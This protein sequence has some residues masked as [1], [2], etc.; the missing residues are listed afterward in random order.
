VIRARPGPPRRRIAT[1]VV[2]WFDG[3][4]G[5]TRIVLF[6]ALLAAAAALLAIVLVPAE[7]PAKAPFT[8]PW[9]F[10]AGLFVV[11]EAKVI[12]VHLGRSAHSLS[13]SEIPIVIGLFLVA[14]P[15]FIVSRLVG[16]GLGL[17]F[18][19]RQS[20]VKILFNLA[21]FALCSVI[22]VGVVHLGSTAG[23]DLGP[24][25]W[26]AV[27]TA[28]LLENV[29]GIL[30][31]STAISLA[32]GS[33][34]Y[35]RLPEMLKVGTMISMTNA[36]LALMGVTVVWEKP[37]AAWLFIVPI[38]TAA[39]AYRAYL[40]ER[41]RHEA[42]EMLHESTLIL[43][44]GPHLDAALI[45]LLDHVRKMFGA[46]VAEIC[47]MPAHEGD[48]ILRARVGPGDLL[49]VMEPI[50]PALDDPLLMRAVT[51]R[52]AF[53][54]GGS[55]AHEHSLRPWRN[56]LVAPLHGESRLIGTLLV[57][58]A[59]SDISTFGAEDLKLFETLAGHTA[60]SL[61]KGQLEQSLAKLSELK[62]ELRHQAYHDAL[63]GLA[64]RA[65]FAQL[66][67]QRLAAP[68]PEGLVPV[69]L[70]LDLD[71]FKLVNDSLGHATGDA[72]LVSVGNRIRESVRTNDVAA[73][74][75]GD[76]FAV[77]LWDEANMLASMRI[78]NRLTA[79]F[80]PGVE[81]GGHAVM[82]RASIGVAAGH[83]GIET[84][85]ELLRNADVA[86]YSAKARGKGRVV[87]FETSM[88]EAVVAR[89]Q[90]SADLERAAAAG[91][92]LLQ[93]QPIVDLATG[94]IAGAEALVRWLHPERGR[95]QPD[96]FIRVAEESEAILEI[97]RWVL[98]EACRQAR[99]WQDLLSDRQFTVS[100][101]IA[102]R[103]LA[104][105]RFV[106]EVLAI[107]EAAGVRPSTMVLEM[108]ETVM[109]L[110]TAATEQK[111]GEL[112]DAGIGIS[113][114]DFGTG[115][116]SLSYLQ[117]FPVTVL[118]IARDFV[119]VE[120]SNPEAWELASAIIALGRALRLTIVAEGVERRSQVGRLRAL[121]CAFAQGYYFARPLDPG[122][123]QVLLAQDSVL[124]GPAEVAREL[125]LRRAAAGGGHS[126]PFSAH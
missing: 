110:E 15:V 65:L 101:N 106:N 72:V 83:P 29:L 64:N 95:L 97:G 74:L 70:F 119:D 102:A 42:L 78:A 19:R 27:L 23:G 75:G 22:S 32:E 77:L 104:Q 99:L 6:S 126:E 61:E 79:S 11:A 84:A 63:T 118:K 92:F 20:P 71:D 58:D 103:Q 37:T 55:G 2:A 28:M 12:H 113:V 93:Y 41:Q 112:R 39:L 18:G 60:V 69:V 109:H 105:P 26:L 107:V 59:V 125:P 1:S 100:V 48:D 91:E 54:V 9:W 66:V 76:E 53:I 98:T 7:A 31:V 10:L 46:N 124:S 33:S 17:Y 13:M 43:Q 81:L 38:V 115:Y 62:E 16:S 51:E 57:A 40:S 34:Q 14:P 96:E 114:D 117:R 121:G 67:A 35:R 88:H 52:K 111:L 123:L 25:L 45:S 21:Q 3:K 86:M 47:L 116:S 120:G 30:A 24:T 80:G 122:A 36:S 56:A 8:I 44:G 50:G 5:T 108:T 49:I 85:G 89:A 73:R 87:V 68:S 4:R 90:L 82:V 94:R